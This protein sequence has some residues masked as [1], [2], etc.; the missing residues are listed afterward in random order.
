MSK[1]IIGAL[2]A[3][4]LCASLVQ[5]GDQTKADTHEHMST[6]SSTASSG[7][8]ALH[9]TMMKG[10]QDMNSMEMSGD[11]DRDFAAMMI[12]HHQQAIDM[13]RAQ[14]KSGKDPQVRKKA[15]E[16]IAASEKDIADLKAWSS[17]RQASSK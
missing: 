17:R 14:L 3:L 13:S 7:S 15:E 11:T 8:K 10:M 6:A 4:V 16:I 1:S 2:S 12:Q 9:E 5:A